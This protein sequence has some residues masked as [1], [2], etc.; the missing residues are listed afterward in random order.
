[1]PLETNLPV[2]LI[3]EGQNSKPR[4][5][6]DTLQTQFPPWDFGGLKESSMF[7]LLPHL[8]IIS[9]LINIPDYSKKAHLDSE[10]TECVPGILCKGLVSSDGQV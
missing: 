3:V 9:F 4:Q 6:G 7:V 5:P 1:M 10:R 2:P 8:F